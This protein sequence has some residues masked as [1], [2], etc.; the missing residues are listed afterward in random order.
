M[1][2]DDPGDATLFVQALFDA[3]EVGDIAVFRAAC[4]EGGTI[5]HNYDKQ[6]RPLTHTA[7]ALLAMS[8]VMRDVRYADRRYFSV[9]GGVIAE[10]V[11]RGTTLSG[12][13]VDVP[14]VAH[15]HISDGKISHIA[16]YLDPAQSAP[17]LAEFG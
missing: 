2:F 14:I 9:S 1:T 7:E 3:V 13:A 4:A 11:L 17:I 12:N 8:K 6:T 5:W 10:H 15:I 16:E